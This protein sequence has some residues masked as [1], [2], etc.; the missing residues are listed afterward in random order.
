M[1]R[2]R[3]S[4]NWPRRVSSYEE[5]TDTLEREGVAKFSDSFEQ[6]LDGAAREAG[7]ARLGLSCGRRTPA[8]RGAVVRQLPAGGRCG[9]RRP[10]QARRELRVRDRDQH[11]DLQRPGRERFGVEREHAVVVP[12][13]TERAF[14]GDVRRREGK[15]LITICG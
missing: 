14:G 7:R 8:W 6:L 13:I 4:S 2:T 9:A 11:R 10:G 15:L 3:C 12:L 1:R 5:I